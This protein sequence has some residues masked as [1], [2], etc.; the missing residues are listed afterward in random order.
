MV[1]G[2]NRVFWVRIL[3]I[4]MALLLLGLVALEYAIRPIL[5]DM[6]EGYMR[7]LAV[8]QLNRAAVEECNKADFS[9]IVTVHKDAEGGVT[10]V[11]TNAALMNVYAALI[12]DHAQQRIS[13]H[14]ALGLNIPLGALFG[15]QIFGVAGPKLNITCTPVSSVTTT[16]ESTF[17][18]AGINQTRHRI[19]AKMHVWIR[20]MFPSGSRV[21]EV[22]GMVM[23]YEG[24]IVGR[25]PQTHI[26]GIGEEELWD[27][28]P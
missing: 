28:V 1:R 9:Q 10:M 8:R 5:G 26:S 6:A 22:E 14:G 20:V 2:K 16:F 7:S 25:V 12:A 15:G 23:V 4:I 18:D 24:I 19:H 3:L 11:S 27:L 13:E 21:V 17:D